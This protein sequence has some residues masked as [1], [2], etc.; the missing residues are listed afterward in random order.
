ME[1]IKVF[2]NSL[3]KYLTLFRQNSGALYFF[4]FFQCKYNYHYVLPALSNK[5]LLS[6]SS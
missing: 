4:C 6:L 1:F 5:L 3:W 2:P